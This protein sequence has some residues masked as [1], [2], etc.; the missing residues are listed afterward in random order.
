MHKNSVRGFDSP[1]CPPPWLRAYAHLTL[2]Q[3]DLIFYYLTI[4]LEYCT[5]S[6][7]LA[8]I[9]AIASLQQATHKAKKKLYMG[10]S[11]VCVSFAC[12]YTVK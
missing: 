7:K 9:K 6:A 1:V 4:S 2:W 11:A 10:V 8:L 12:A 3:T 5:H